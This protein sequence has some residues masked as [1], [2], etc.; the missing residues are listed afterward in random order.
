MELHSLLGRHPS[1]LEV[2][3][4]L[5]EAATAKQKNS[6]TAI[7]TTATT[8]AGTSVPKPTV[9]VYKDAVY[10]SYPSLGISF[11]YE[12]SQPLVPSSYSSSTTP[13]PSLLTLAA[14]HLYRRPADKFETFP[15]S[16]VVPKKSGSN[17]AVVLVEMDMEK[18]GHEIVQLLGEP[19]EKQGGGRKGNCWI[20]YHGSSTS[21]GVSMDFAGADWEDR[22]M[23][24]ACLTVAL[25]SSTS[26]S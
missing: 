20:G 16:F 6:N 18:R 21:A 25:P 2:E 12:S 24:L 17:E 23:V 4:L 22:E 5:S 14:I 10:Y 11:N 9:K 15:L 19:D 13:D 3:A 8:A 7:A 26:P 1:S